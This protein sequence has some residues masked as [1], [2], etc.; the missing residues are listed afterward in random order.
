LHPSRS[1]R[2]PFLTCLR[3]DLFLHLSTSFPVRSRVSTR[4]R[5]RRFWDLFS[6][7]PHLHTISSFIPRLHLIFAESE[8][9]FMASFGSLLDRRTDTMTTGS[10][11]TRR[12]PSVPHASA[13]SSRNKD[14][15]DHE[16][17]KSF[18]FLAPGSRPVVAEAVFK[19]GERCMKDGAVRK[20]HEIVGHVLSH[21]EPQC[22]D[23]RPCIDVGDAVSSPALCFGK[24]DWIAFS[25]SIAQVEEDLCCTSLFLFCTSIVF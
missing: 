7:A 1:P 5:V 2:L 17:W 14:A 10:A 19:S 20:P 22:F 13:L 18:N 21:Q 8:S 25:R 11:P 23:C 15:D 9:L 16:C 24:R 3:P 12:G 6:W 4:L